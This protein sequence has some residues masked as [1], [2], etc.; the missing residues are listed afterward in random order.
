MMV[1]ILGVVATYTDNLP[2]AG[3]LFVCVSLQQ[4]ELIWF[5]AA[6]EWGIATRSRVIWKHCTGNA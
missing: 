2:K 4:V 3:T 1:A 5:P 6:C